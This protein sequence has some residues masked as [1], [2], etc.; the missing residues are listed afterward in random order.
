MDD[1]Q[2]HDQNLAEELLAVSRA[3]ENVGSRMEVDRPE[4]KS[5]SAKQR[6][7]IQDEVTG[8]VR[9]VL[10]AKVREIPRGCRKKN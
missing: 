3:L 6:I 1:L 5:F 10:L 7:S 9:L 2:A 8:H 4:S